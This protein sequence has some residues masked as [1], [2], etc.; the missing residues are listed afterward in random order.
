[1][2]GMQDRSL[3]LD[4]PSVRSSACAN[5]AAFK[6]TM[7]TPVNAGAWCGGGSVGKRGYFT[8]GTPAR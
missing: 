3:S 2:K 6:P 4:H 5:H 7:A 1:M 8:S